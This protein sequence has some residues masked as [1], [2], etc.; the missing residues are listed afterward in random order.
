MLRDVLMV[1]MVLGGVAMLVVFAYAVTKFGEVTE[2]QIA[3]RDEA[4]GDGSP[5]R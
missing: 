4:N 5:G 2:R 3:E 1:V